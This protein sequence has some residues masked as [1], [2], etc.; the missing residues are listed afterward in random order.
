MMLY[1]LGVFQAFVELLNLEIENAHV[2]NV[3][4]RKIAVSLAD[5]VDL[6]VI[7]SF[8]YIITEVM[9]AEKE[10]PE[11]EH[12]DL[13]EAFVTEISQPI[14]DELLAVKLL[15]MITR[16]CSASAPHFPMKKVLLLLWKVSLVSLGGTETLKKLKSKLATW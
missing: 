9:R 13:V 2:A 12:K 11:E 3:A 4:I 7:L 10:K 14:G 1:R 6:R 15:G 8:L 5:S 16:F